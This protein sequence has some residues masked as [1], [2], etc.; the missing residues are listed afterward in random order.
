[1]P[2]CHVFVSEAVAAFRR[3]RCGRGRRE[4]VVCNGIDLAPF[5][6]V[7][8]AG[9]AAGTVFGAVGR[10]DRQKGFDVLVRAFARLAREDDAVRLRIAGVGPERGRLSALAAREGVAGRVELAGFVEDVPAFLA[11]LDV[12]VNPSRWEGFGLTLLEALAAGLPCIA[13]RVD[14]LPE[15]GGDFVTWTAPD[16]AEGLCAAMRRASSAP[17]P[18]VAA[19]RQRAYVG[20][21]SQESMAERYLALYRDLT[22]PTPA[23]GR[24]PL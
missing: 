16:D 24:G 3:S 12:F 14:S 1:V 11:S 4:L 21:F 15:V 5:F 9:G 10:L 20:R 23:A 19:G 2:E 8:P 6:A 18:P 7:S 17:G 13:S 22:G